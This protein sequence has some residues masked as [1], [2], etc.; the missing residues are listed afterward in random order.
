MTQETEKRW[1]VDDCRLVSPD[2]IT[3]RSDLALKGAAKAEAG[4]IADACNAAPAL[5]LALAPFAAAYDKF[6]ALFTDEEWAAID[7]KTHLVFMG[8]SVADLQKSRDTLDEALR[9]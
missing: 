2:G 3:W 8:L 1:K 7:P 4:F 6:R 5:I 9:K